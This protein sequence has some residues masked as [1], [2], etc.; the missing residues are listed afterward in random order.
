[1]PNFHGMVCFVSSIYIY[2]YVSLCISICICISI[3]MSI[4]MYYARKKITKPG[5]CLIAN[6]RAFLVHTIKFS[7][8]FLLIIFFASVM[9]SVCTV[10]L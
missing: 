10:S 5:I 9:L 7:N 1:M 4:S 6:Q 8:S 2:I 3:S